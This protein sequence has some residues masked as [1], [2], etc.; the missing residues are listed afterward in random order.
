MNQNYNDL[1]L[2]QAGIIIRF[3]K[4]TE[5]TGNK[6]AKKSKFNDVAGLLSEGAGN[7]KLLQPVQGQALVESRD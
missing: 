1:Q 3:T 6:N 4:F 5:Q 2:I 7:S